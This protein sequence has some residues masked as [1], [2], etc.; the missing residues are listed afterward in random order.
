MTLAKTR[1]GR[2]RCKNAWYGEKP[3][4]PHFDAQADLA[5]FPNQCEGGTNM[6]APH[7]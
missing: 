6:M 5:L 4:A 3:S 2:R 7:S 1:S